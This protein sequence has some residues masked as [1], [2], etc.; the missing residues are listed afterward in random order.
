MGNEGFRV[1]VADDSLLNQEML[2]RILAEYNNELQGD[3]QLPYLIDFAKSGPEA[4]DRIQQ[5]KPDLL[6]LDIIMPG[7][8]GFEVL[9]ILKSSDSTKAI[10]VVIITGLSDESYEEKGLLRGAVDY[11]TK[12]FRKPVVMARINTQRKVVE[13]MRLIEMHSMIDQLTGIPNRRSFDTRMEEQ[14]GYARRKREHIGVLMVDIDHFKKYN[15]TYGHQQGDETL[16]MVAGVITEALMRSSDYAF[17]WGGEEFT[18]LLVD[19][20][21]PGAIIVGERVREAV[22]S[23][24]VPNLAGGE[25]LKVTVSVGVSSIV[26]GSGD[27]IPELIKQADRGVYAAK[28]SGRN[29]VCTPPSEQ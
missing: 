17:R 27:E 15:D 6:L 7:M 28:E 29:K 11:I 3:E 9:E 2:R 12:P 14:W 26:P 1:L 22:E 25:P 19:T 24:L 21:L 5:A 10:P 20:D 4:L 18:A 8:D 16:K 13:Q 23:T